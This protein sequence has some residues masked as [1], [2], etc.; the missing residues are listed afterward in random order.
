M[1]IE[2]GTLRMHLSGE[3]R[4]PRKTLQELILFETYESRQ[5][6]PF[7]LRMICRGLSVSH[8]NARH[9][10][11]RSQFQ[12]TLISVLILYAFCA[13]RIAHNGLALGA[14][15]DFGAQNCQYTTKVDA[16]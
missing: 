2:S 12:F 16:G 3:C 15:A 9:E 6:R 4:Q 14:V 5:I 10:G 7:F 13:A 8:E 1:N 11:A